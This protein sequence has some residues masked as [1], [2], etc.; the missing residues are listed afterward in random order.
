LDP[1]ALNIAPIYL[2][3]ALV[4]R[5][6]GARVSMSGGFPSVFQIAAI[7]EIFY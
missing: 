3:R 1:D 5:L 4:V 6:R 2:F 7:G